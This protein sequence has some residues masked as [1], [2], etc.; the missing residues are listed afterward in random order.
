MTKEQIIE[1]M[2]CPR[3]GWGEDYLKP[4]G[5]IKLT[6]LEYEMLKYTQK[7]GAKY[8]CKDEDGEINISKNK[9]RR[10]CTMWLTTG[11]EKIL[12]RGY[13]KN[14]FEFVKWEDEPRLIEDILNNYEIV[15]DE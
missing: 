1:C 7:Q 3:Y 8:I 14:L 4:L 15:E 2:E 10:G 13:L 5:P 6:N 11:Q 9:P 12:L